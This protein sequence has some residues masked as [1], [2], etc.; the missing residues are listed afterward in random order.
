MSSN[1]KPQVGRP[2]PERGSVIEIAVGLFTLEFGIGVI[3]LID[4]FYR[5][6]AAINNLLS[7]YGSERM[8]PSIG[9]LIGK[10]LGGYYGEEIGNAIDNLIVLTLTGGP[11]ADAEEF[12]EIIGNSNPDALIALLKTL[13]FLSGFVDTSEMTTLIQNWLA[14][15]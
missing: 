12:I 9:A 13:S 4:A 5:M 14:T 2:A 8:A 1:N 15:H 10:A 6:S 3:V 7:N 11:I